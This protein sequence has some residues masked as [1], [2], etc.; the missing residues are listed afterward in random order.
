MKGQR[1]PRLRKRPAEGGV[2]AKLIEN[3]KTNSCKMQLLSPTNPYTL[4]NQTKFMEI[5]YRI[6]IIWI[7]HHFWALPSFGKDFVKSVF[8]GLKIIKKYWKT[9][10][11]QL[12]IVR[13]RN[14]MN[15]EPFRG[16]SG[17]LENF[18]EKLSFLCLKI[19][20]KY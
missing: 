3:F 6:D 4:K 7:S 16:I 10:Q 1:N 13:N 11:N 20:L 2:K 8:L 18:E 12:K 5:L 17:R 14:H 15:F 9:S 19:A